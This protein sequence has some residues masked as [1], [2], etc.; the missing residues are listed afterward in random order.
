VSLVDSYEK[1]L[2]ILNAVDIVYST[3]LVDVREYPEDVDVALVEGSVCLSHK[4]S[5]ELI[6]KVRENSKIVVA[7]GSCS[8]CG[9]VTRFSRGGQLGRPEHDSFSP[10]TEV[11]DV[12]FSLV[13][14]PPGT[15]SIVKLILALLNGNEDYLK[16]YKQA[17]ELS[18]ADGRL[19]FKRVINKGLCIGCGTCAA[20]C[21]TRAITIVDGRP[22][23]NEGRCINCGVCIFQCPRYFLP[24]EFMEKK[25]KEGSL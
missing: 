11:I 8:A 14:C 23:I 10:V 18:E 2:E 13:G 5:V 1:L 4:E 12:D 9:G 6:K 21:Q 20:S 17:V 19:L 16:P 25:V 3:T 24:L 15:E 7:L 22:E